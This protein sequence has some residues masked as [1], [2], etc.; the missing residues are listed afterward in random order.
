MMDVEMEDVEKNSKQR[1]VVIPDTN[2][3]VR[4]LFETI[5]YDGTTTHDV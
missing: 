2:I 4:M 5:E 1:L 3:F